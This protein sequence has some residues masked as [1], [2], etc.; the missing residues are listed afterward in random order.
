MTRA[1]ILE[2]GCR[3][4]SVQGLGDMTIGVLSADVQMSKSGLY[5]HFRSKEALQLA[6]LDAVADRFVAAVVDPAE[7]AGSPLSRLRRLLDLW[8]S[9]TASSLPGGCLLLSAVAEFDDQPGK[10]RDRIAA[11]HQSWRTLLESVIAE[12]ASDGELDRLT[13]AGQLAFELTGA[14]L[15]YYHAH[16]LLRDEAAERRARHALNGLINRHQPD[17]S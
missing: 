1:V 10:V 11:L 3:L 8:V 12:A 6:V 13:D 15:A 16:R 9:W 5:A 4:A 17:P 7:E 14:V 2:H